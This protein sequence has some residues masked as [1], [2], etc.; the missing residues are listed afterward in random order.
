MKLFLSIL[1]ACMAFILPALAQSSLR[2]DVYNGSTFGEVSVPLTANALLGFG[3]S[4]SPALITLGS[5]LTLTGTTLSAAG[6]S[7]SSITGKPSTLSGFG[8]TDG[9]T[10]AAAAAAYAPLSHTQAIS[11]ITG[12]QTA[13]DG[14]AATSHTQAWSSITSTPTTLSGYGITD[15]VT[16]SAAAAA[17]APLNH[18]QEVSS[19]NGL[20]DLLDFKAPLQDPNFLG[21]ISVDSVP[22]GAAAFAAIGPYEY[23]LLQW[24]SSGNT[25]SPASVVTTTALGAVKR[26]SS[27]PVDL[28]GTGAITASQAINNLLPSQSAQAGQYLRSDGS[29]ASWEPLAF[30]SII[31]GIN[32]VQLTD[33]NLRYSELTHSQLSF[34]DGDSGM[35]VQIDTPNISS[36][37]LLTWPSQSGTLLTDSSN[38]AAAKLTGTIASARLPTTITGLTSVTSTTFVGNLTGTASGNLVAG[39]ALGTPNSGVLTN[40]TSIP[41]AQ[42]TGTINT[43]RLPATITGITSL[44]STTLT[45]AN[46]I[47]TGLSLTGAQATNTIDVATTWNT[48]GNPSLIYGRVTNTASGANARLLSLGTVAA[49]ELIGITKTGA[50]Y[51]TSAAGV[52]NG[53]INFQLGVDGGTTSQT[54]NLVYGGGVPIRLRVGNNQCLTLMPTDGIVSYGY[55]GINT[56]ADGLGAAV[57]LYQDAANIMAQRNSTTA[58]AFRVANTYTSATN[59]EYGV[60]DWRTTT[61]TLRIGSSKGSGGGSNRAVHFIMGDAVEMR[62]DTDGNVVLPALPTTAPATSGALWRDAANGN[63]LKVVP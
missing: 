48:T 52:Y 61:N 35:G 28:G 54:L 27:L 53:N 62:F 24:A 47:Y 17:Y 41:A 12:L 19:I 18:T 5:G 3:G 32:S 2:L 16:A 59:N 33:G 11:T 58:Q 23:Q 9:I 57:A 49:G 42:L 60:I 31:T 55:L 7:W 21:S 51:S 1:L 34:G 46:S 50:F 14:K 63:V 25:Q 45:S 40:C 13:L 39:G 36:T 56:V 8:I 4:G 6:G 30:P 43:A 29:N 38:L 15:A 22:L 44:T 37:V 10:A 26:I 20:Q